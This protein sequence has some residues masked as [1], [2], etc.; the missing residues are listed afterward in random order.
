MPEKKPFQ[1]LSKHVKKKFKNIYFKIL[2][3]HSISDDGFRVIKILD[4][5]FIDGRVN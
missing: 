3:S 5:I 4:G 2:L 1:F